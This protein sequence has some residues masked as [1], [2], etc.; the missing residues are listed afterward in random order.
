MYAWVAV[1]LFDNEQIV[2]TCRIGPIAL[3]KNF[4]FTRYDFHST[5]VHCK[6]CIEF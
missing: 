3:S 6:V 4:K 1:A 2:H 5:S